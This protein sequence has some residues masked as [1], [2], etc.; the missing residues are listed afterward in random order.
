MEVGIRE[1]R[2]YSK[3]ACW[4]KGFKF[5]A[6]PTPRAIHG[7]WIDWIGKCLVRVAIVNEIC[8]FDFLIRGWGAHPTYKKSKWRIGCSLTDDDDVCTSVCVHIKII[9]CIYIICEESQRL[10]F[11][12]FQ[13]IW[14]L[15]SSHVLNTNHLVVTH[16]FLVSTWSYKPCHIPTQI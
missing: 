11:R 5:V 3:A 13:V 6:I 8:H 14:V 10:S 7:R 1:F 16:V 12:S 15:G 9:V 2:V 4:S